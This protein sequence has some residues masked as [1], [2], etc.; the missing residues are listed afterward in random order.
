M[1]RGASLKSPDELTMD[2]SHSTVSAM[3]Q[4]SHSHSV[5]SADSLWSRS[6]RLLD[7]DDSDADPGVPPNPKGV[8]R[9]HLLDESSGSEDKHNLGD[10]KSS[11]EGSMG[12]VILTFPRR[13]GDCKE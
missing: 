13:I 10:R 6:W 7:K 5:Q 8:K 3:S 12:A 9:M 4:Q 1:S 2:S 11:A